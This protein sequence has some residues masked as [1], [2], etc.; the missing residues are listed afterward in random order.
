MNSRPR[1][2]VWARSAKMGP[3]E[4]EVRT[5]VAPSNRKVSPPFDA[6]TGMLET[7]A[8]TELVRNEMMVAFPST[9]AGMKCDPWTE[10]AGFGELAEPPRKSGASPCPKMN[11]SV[12]WSSRFC[13]RSGAAPRAARRRL[14]RHGAHETSWE[15]RVPQ[16]TGHPWL[17]RLPRTRSTACWTSPPSTSSPSRTPPVLPGRFTMRVD[18]RTPAV[19]RESAARGNRG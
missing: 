1:P 13:A 10:I 2:S 5:G 18:P 12:S 4:I 11:R 16:L 8:L 9:A 7:E 14:R 15:M 6:L 19:P 3:A 17:V